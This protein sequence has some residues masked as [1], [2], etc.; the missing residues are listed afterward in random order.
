MRSPSPAS[1][2]AAARN[3]A[4]HQS[5]MRGAGERCPCRAPHNHHFARY[6]RC[7]V[8][9]PHGAAVRLGLKRSTLQFRMQKLGIS[10]RARVID[11]VP[12]PACR[13]R[14][15]PASTLWH[16][17]QRPQSP[18]LCQAMG[19]LP[20]PCIS[21][22]ACLLGPRLPAPRLACRSH[23]WR[24][25]SSVSIGGH[26]ACTASGWP[27]FSPSSMPNARSCQRRISS[28]IVTPA[29]PRPSWPSLR[30]WVGVGHRA[31]NG[32]LEG[33]LRALSMRLAALCMPRGT[34]GLAGR[35]RCAKLRGTD[36]YVFDS[37][38]EGGKPMLKITLHDA[39][40]P[41]RLELEGR[42]AGHGSM[43]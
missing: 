41:L 22:L 3:R 1:R 20:S 15:P 16:H 6:P 43:S 40:E 36:A 27:T 18:E 35:H 11:G 39:V 28:Q 21:T 30:P 13:D 37:G 33:A 7:V 23:R 9:G 29:P 24:A 8:A 38:T 32:L 5:S 14:R 25:T 12:S 10:R 19:V 26:G 2:I 17:H 31:G 4:S 34:N 42:L